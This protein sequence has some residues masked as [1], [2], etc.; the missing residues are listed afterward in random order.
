[1]KKLSI[2]ILDYFKA[3]KVIKN[4]RSL[5]E[6]EVNF[7]FEIHI[8]DN[9]CN[10][11]NAFLLQTLSDNKNVRITTNKIN[12]GY[13]VPQNRLIKELENEYILILNPDIFWK[14]KSSLQKIVDFM[15]KNKDIGI[16]GPKQVDENGNISM[17]VRA[18]PKL[19]VQISRRT[20]LRELPVLKDLVEY[21][22]MKHLDYS[23]IQEVDW[24]QSSC[25]MIR[26]ELWDDIG[27]FNEN[28]FLFMADVELCLESWKKDMKVVYYPE[29]EVN[30]DGIRCSRGGVASFFKN[31]ILRTHVKDAI[32]Y[33]LNHWKEKNPRTMKND[34]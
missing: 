6:Q 34:E 4:V 10:K 16:I 14:D 32:K 20:F 33:Q 27:G 29:V 21:D 19:H 18:F 28:Y 22:E 5:L 17:S 26:R 12:E 25:I 13:S 9:S 31:W 8:I 30:A 7:V 23:K 1:M 15:D 2:I 11:S 3:S 24:L